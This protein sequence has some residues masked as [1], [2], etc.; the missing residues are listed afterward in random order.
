MVE[1]NH[2]EIAKCRAEKEFLRYDQSLMVEKCGLTADA[3]F[4]YISFFH[5]PYRIGRKSGH[6]ERILPD[7]GVDDADFNV[8][9]TIFDILCEIKPGRY[10]ADVWMGLEKFSK[11]AFNGGSLFRPYAEAFDGKT[12]SLRRA[13]AKYGGRP[14]DCSGDVA[15]CLPLFE[16]FPVIFRFWDGD[17]ELPPTLRFLW[18]AHTLNYIRFETMFYAMNHILETL[19]HEMNELNE[20]STKK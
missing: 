6:V 10:L 11:T 14:V 12:E 4:L 19:T 17:E 7:G 9:M 2:Y 16:F 1:Q 15:S 18:D 13:C 8:S 20:Y 5:Q 3:D